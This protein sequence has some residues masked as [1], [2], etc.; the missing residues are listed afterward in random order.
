MWPQLQVEGFVARD[1]STR[2]GAW[3]VLTS[4]VGQGSFSFLD[5]SVIILGR[6]DIWRMTRVLCAGHHL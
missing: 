4:L 5:F 6:K 1:S 3:R 2:P